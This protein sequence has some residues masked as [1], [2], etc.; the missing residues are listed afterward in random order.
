MK[1]FF[2]LLICTYYLYS[3]IHPNLNYLADT[4]TW[5]GLLHYEENENKSSILNKDFFLAQ[6]GMTNKT[7]ELQETIKRFENNDITAICKYPA[8][9]LWLAKK[10]S[11]KHEM[12]V[13][14]QC[15]SYNN[16]I[17]MKNN[18]SISIVFVSGFLGNPASAFGHSF[19]KL[20]QKNTINHL[21]D[22][23]ISYGAKLPSS[24]SMLSYM[25]DGLFEDIAQGLVIKNIIW[26]IWHIQI[27][28]L[29]ICGNIN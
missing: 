27:K 23:T 16:W 19:F 29:E 17:L 8:R 9:Y 15:K 20:N 12:R 10:L 25:V 6:D 22:N 4:K 24:Y 5:R 2:L 18:D 13:L 28:I 1:F 11:W 7:H 26:M 21:L 14:T 3:S